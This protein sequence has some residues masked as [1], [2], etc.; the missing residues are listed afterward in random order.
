[1]TIETKDPEATYSLRY[2]QFAHVMP[3]INIRSPFAL[4][5]LAPPPPPRPQETGGWTFNAGVLG[6]FMIFQNIAA[7]NKIAK[8]KRLFHEYSKRPGCQESDHP[9]FL[10]GT[11]LS[12]TWDSVCTHSDTTDVRQSVDVRFIYAVVFQQL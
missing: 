1:M 2:L 8:L 12:D 7:E 3:D 5:R 9:S 6:G 10:G 11:T 4:D